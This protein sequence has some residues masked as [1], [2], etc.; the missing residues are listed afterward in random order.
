M[1]ERNSWRLKPFIY[2]GKLH[3]HPLVL[4]KLDST[5][6]NFKNWHSTSFF[7]NNRHSDLFCPSLT[8]N[9]RFQTKYSIFKLEYSFF[10]SVLLTLVNRANSKIEIDGMNN[11]VKS[12]GK[13]MGKIRIVNTQIS[14]ENLWEKSFIPAAMASLGGISIFKEQRS[15]K[16][17]VLYNQL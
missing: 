5:H 13:F 6:P 7:E 14:E 10:I 15:H 11:K 8:N 3:W 4:V 17:I 16:I 9:V 2:F 1:R 12:W